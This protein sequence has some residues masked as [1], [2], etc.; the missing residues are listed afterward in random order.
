MFVTINTIYRV[1]ILSIYASLVID[2]Y[3]QHVK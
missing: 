3:N 2:G 1:S